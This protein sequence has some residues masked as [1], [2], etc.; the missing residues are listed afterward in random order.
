MHATD[1]S[2]HRAFG[3]VSIVCAAEKGQAAAR[4]APWSKTMPAI[5]GK[6]P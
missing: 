6:A 2:S 4:P 1:I 5:A 3:A